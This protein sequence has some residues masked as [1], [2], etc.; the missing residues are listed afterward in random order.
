MYFFCS[1]IFLLVVDR[2]F[3]GNFF[4]IFFYCV[5]CIYGYSFHPFRKWEF[6][7]G[8]FPFSPLSY[9]VSHSFDEIRLSRCVKIFVSLFSTVHAKGEKISA[10]EN[11]SKLN[12]L[13][14]PLNGEFPLVNCQ[15][16]VW[17]RNVIQFS[18]AR[19]S[20]QVSSYVN[21]TFTGEIQFAIL[22]LRMALV[23]VLTIGRGIFES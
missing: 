2:R 19:S 15:V 1:L 23:L 8:C 22:K 17:P 13:S 9:F 4:I 12:N 7:R 5:L 20:F 18:S 16:F 10:F 21:F 3:E 6:T 11:H 14:V